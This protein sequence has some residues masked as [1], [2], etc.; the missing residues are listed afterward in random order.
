[1]AQPSPEIKAKLAQLKAEAK[2]RAERDIQRQKAI[3]NAEQAAGQPVVLPTDKKAKG[4]SVMGINVAS[5]RK[6]DRN[7][8]DLIVDGHKTLESR[9]GDSLRPYVGK[10]VA[11]VRTGAGPA[12]AIGEVT[13]GEPM[14]VNSKKFRELEH[15]HMVPKGSAFDINTPTK[16]LYPL[17]DPERYE[18]ERDVGHGIVARKVMHKADGGSIPSHDVMRL[19]IGGSGPRNWLK[20]TVD[21]VTEPLKVKTDQFAQR[22]QERGGMLSS[23]ERSRIQQTNPANLSLNQ[24]IESNLANYIKKQMGGPND[25]VRKLAEEGILHFDPNTVPTTLAR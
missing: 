16:H 4:G 6:A 2:I 10:R 13:I 7:Y 15:K 17:H 18:A 22:I 24:W 8:A 23:A 12:K 9:N 1:M 25:P 19:A 3:R 5:D 20:G 11:I 14:V 21:K